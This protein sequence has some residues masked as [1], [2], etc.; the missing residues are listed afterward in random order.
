MVVVEAILLPILLSMRYS[1][2]E[3]TRKLSLRSGILSSL[4]ELTLYSLWILVV[5]RGE[6][7]RGVTSWVCTMHLHICYGGQ[8]RLQCPPTPCSPWGIRLPPGI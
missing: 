3:F 8:L 6:L 1:I 5:E 7:L 2:I 4:L